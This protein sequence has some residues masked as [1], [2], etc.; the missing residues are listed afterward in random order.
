MTDEN[1]HQP[2][3]L[4]WLAMN[5]LLT[6]IKPDAMTI[7]L[8]HAWPGLVNTLLQQAGKPSPHLWMVMGCLRT[9]VQVLEAQVGFLTALWLLQ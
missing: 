6:L 2:P 5:V 8:Q 9:I 4:V 7:L 3:H 1:F